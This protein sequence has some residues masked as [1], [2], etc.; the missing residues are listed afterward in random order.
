MTGDFNLIIGSM[1]LE[2]VIKEERG[3]IICQ[4][5]RQTERHA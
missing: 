5:R 3:S 4:K 2:N 1:N